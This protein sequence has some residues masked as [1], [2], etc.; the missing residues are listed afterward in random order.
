MIDHLV[1]RGNLNDLGIA[2]IVG[3]ALAALVGS[4]C[5]PQ[6]TGES[7]APHLYEHV[8]DQPHNFFARIHASEPVHER[9]RT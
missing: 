7:H 2:L 3:L 1:D 4:G 8:D 6:Q 5:S 9:R